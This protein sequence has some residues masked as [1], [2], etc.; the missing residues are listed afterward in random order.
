MPDIFTALART[1]ESSCPP[2][3]TWLPALDPSPCQEKGQ[4][5]GYSFLEKTPY[6]TPTT[7]NPIIRRD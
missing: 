5:P 4:A 3:R 7:H 6:R 1:S 2:S